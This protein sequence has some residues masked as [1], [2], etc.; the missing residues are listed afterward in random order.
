MSP[1]AGAKSMRALLVLALVASSAG[2]VLIVATYVLLNGQAGPLF[3]GLS[4]L[5]IGFITGL[6]ALFASAIRGRPSDA[7]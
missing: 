6:L 1:T 7:G 3:A 2:I 5:G 4:L